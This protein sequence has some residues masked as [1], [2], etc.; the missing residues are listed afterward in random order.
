[1]KPLKIP[2]EYALSQNYPNPFNPSTT[3]NFALPEA[4]HV[5]LKIYSLL[6]EEVR[7]LVDK[8]FDEGYHTIQWDGKNNNRNPVSSGIYLYKIQAGDFSQVKKMS[9]LR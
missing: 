4:D 1:M 6:G 2:T 9:L 5:V 8:D 7:I 3:I